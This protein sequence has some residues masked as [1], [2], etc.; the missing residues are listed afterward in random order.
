MFFC[1][2]IAIAE[3]CLFIHDRLCIC[4]QAD[5]LNLVVKRQPEN[6]ILEKK[7]RKRESF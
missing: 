5:K 7:K 6:K 1:N 3:L 2:G 4:S